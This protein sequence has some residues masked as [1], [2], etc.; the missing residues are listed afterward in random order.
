MSKGLNVVSLF[1]GKSCGMIALNK[2]GIKVNNYYA[3][4]I[5]KYAQ[6]VSYAHYPE[7]KRLGDVRNVSWIGLPKIDL[8]IGGS[9]CQG[10]SF[11]G[12]QLNFDDPRSKL[13]FEFVRI[14]EELNPKY[15]LLENVKMKKEYQDVISEYMGVEPILINSALVSAQNRKR[16]YWSNIPNIEQPKDK[17]ILL[18]D[19]L[20]DS[21]LSNGASIK[22]RYLNR[23]S[24]IGRRLN[25][26]GHREDYNKDVK[27]TQCLEVRKDNS[28]SNCLTTVT[29]DNIITN[30]EVGRHPDIYNKSKKLYNVNPSG[31]GMNGWVYDPNY[32][33]PTITTNKGEGSKIRVVEATKKGYTEAGIG[34][35]LDLTFPNSKTRRGRLMKEKCNCL[36]AAN[37]EYG[38][39]ESKIRDKSKCVRTSGRGSYDRHEWDSVDELHW[40][41]LT[42]L[43]CERLQCVPDNYTKVQYQKITKKGNQTKWISNSQ[44]YKM[45]GNGWTIDVIAHIFKNL[46]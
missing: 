5:D 19:I 24:I 42:P 34:E 28:K 14:K 2:A 3:S 35:G 11:A 4:E 38:I 6:I 17:G 37:Y 27:I 25:D 12:K 29:K 45:L 15:F 33:S 1:D 16:L 10:F 22:G 36:T 20:E 41:K 30:I 18:K 31:R 8:L 39:V 40:R 26:A 23:A 21:E 44:R 32:K 46:K 7:I 9:P 43:E 13:F